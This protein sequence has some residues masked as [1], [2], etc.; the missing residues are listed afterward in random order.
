LAG[1]GTLAPDGALPA[2]PRGWVGF[3][4]GRLGGALL[5]KAG[6]KARKTKIGA[7][8]SCIKM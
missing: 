6:E 7:G 4:L 5:P 3:T 2:L 1:T 8:C